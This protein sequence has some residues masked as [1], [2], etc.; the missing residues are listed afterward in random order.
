MSILQ[1]ATSWSS[2]A[3]PWRAILLLSLTAT[4]SA[5]PAATLTWQG[6]IGPGWGSGVPGLDTNWV[7]G[8]LPAPGDS[9]LFNLNQAGLANLVTGNDLTGLTLGGTNAITFTNDAGTDTGFTL[10]GN[11][12]TLGGNIN[13]SGTTGTHAHLISLDLVLNGTRTVTPVQNTTITI[14]GQVG[15]TGGSQG[16][17]KAGQGTL[18]LS[19]TNSFSGP[20]LINQ[21]TLMANSLG[22]SGA[23]SSI[24]AGAVIHLGSGTTTAGTLTYTG[25]G[26]FSNRSVNLAAATTG[27]AALNNNGTGALTFTGVF[28]NA[29]SGA[30]TLT[31]GGSNTGANEIQS[32]LGDGANGGTLAIAKSNGGAW[33][34]TALNSFTGPV[35]VNQGILSVNSIA[36]AG[37]A[38]ALGAGSVVNLGSGAQSGTLFYSGPATSTNRT[39][40]LASAGAGGGVIDASGMG[41]LTL[42]GNVTNAA[43][44]GTK[45]LTL[46]GATIGNEFQGVITDGGNGGVV[47]VTKGD[48]GTWVLSGANTFTGALSVSRAT[49]TVTSLADSGVASAAGAGSVINL[50][51]G[52][53]A[54]TLTYTGS[55]ASTN[56]GVTLASTGT[57]GGTI[58]S[59][60]TG[61]LVLTAA[62]TNTGAS[63]SKTLTL[64]GS[65]TGANEFQGL[66]SNGV[67]GGSLALVKSGAGTWHVTGMNTFTGDVTVTQG[68]LVVNSLAAGGVSSAIGAG[69]TLHLG[70]GA[71]AG[72]LV[73]AGA[74][75]TVD[76]AINLASTG[77]GGGIIT[78]NGEGVLIFS[79]A[80]NNAGTTG[81][82]TL[83]LSGTS[84]DAN[85]FQGVIHDGGAGGTVAVTKS[86]DG[87]WALSGANAYSG[88]TTLN[89]GTLR[90]NH[91]SAIGTGA[92]II[93][94][95][96]LDNTTGAAITLSTGNAVTISGDFAF[97]GT[98]SLDLGGGTVTIGNASRVV[99]LNG[100]STLSLGELRWNSVNAARSL[101]V[102]QGTGSGANLVLGGL[103]LNINTDTAA[104]NRTITGS[105][106]VRIAGVVS[107]GNAFNNG[108]IYSGSGTLTLS[109]ANTYSGRTQVTAGTLVVNGST[110]SGSVTVSAGAAL[111]G[112]GTAGSISSGSTFILDSG[113]RLFAGQAHVLDAQTLTLQADASFMLRG[114]VELDIIGGYTSGV[115]N[116]SGGNNDILKFTSSA[117]SGL[118]APVLNGATL[119]LRTGVGLGAGSWTPGTAFKLFDWAGLLGSFDNLPAGGA[120]TGNPDDLPDLS[121]A[122]LAWD[123][124]QLYSSGVISVTTMVPEPSRMFLMM[125]GVVALLLRRRRPPVQQ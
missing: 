92:F 50:G 9:L 88:N 106:D 12:V 54:G 107:N 40:H 124:S 98:Q 64:G 36:N 17:V 27:G 18:V 65:N 83:T 110:G 59:S 57:G 67:A 85:Q 109:G 25:A 32:I 116:M 95:G 46:N 4:T 51:G 91:T 66:I 42:T 7:A 120:Q 102:N 58:N 115:L 37:S 26:G 3:R 121:Q 119:Q 55:G 31:F 28:T 80:F 44:S 52:A 105:A 69:S 39:I 33:S 112:S 82:K 70:S 43:T 123:W 94:G 103:M 100:G 47:A 15:E 114:R 34:L 81:T 6:D 56:R 87:T 45:T 78:H 84:T 38:S 125:S 79:G 2:I 23:A 71:N 93:A 89:A 21:G 13:S 117:G 99:T 77:A 14:Q 122:G 19:G 20:V 30:K 8:T 16:L 76:R 22:D 24:G 29:G 10:S 96:T 62:L 86:G 41:S 53:Q 74:G 90:L 118:G 104:R 48:T 113:G 60:G 75:A 63:G 49:L 1:Q 73:Y 61:P 68:S 35:S 101:T 5:L 72:T 97:G 108:L 11:A 111:G